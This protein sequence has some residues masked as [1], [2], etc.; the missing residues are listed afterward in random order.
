MP[1]EGC[2][3][4]PRSGGSSTELGFSRWM[5]RFH[6]RQSEVDGE[7]AHDNDEEAGE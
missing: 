3:P 6:M 2:A 4:A 7:L 5:N 1:D